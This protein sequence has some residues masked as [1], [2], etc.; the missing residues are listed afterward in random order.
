[1]HA[2]VFTWGFTGILGKLIT[3]DYYQIVF[4]RVMIAGFSLLV[5][6]LATKKTFRIKN[7][8]DVWKT[9][10]IGVLVMLHW[11]TF[12]K[13]IQ[14]STTSVA[15]LCLSTTTLHVSW[16][17]PI[18]MKRKFI[19]MEFIL[20]LGV[21]GGISFVAG[22]IGA[23]QYEG[24]FWGLIS[25]LMAAF[26]SVFNLRLNMDGIKS[27]SLT[28]YEMFVAAACLGIVLLSS[29]KMNAAFFQVEE[30][31]WIWLFLLGIVCTTAPFMLMIDVAKKLGAFT[32]SLTINLEPVYS[33][34]LAIIILHENEILG[35][36]FYWGALLI[37]MI[38]F[39]NPILKHYMN[40]RKKSIA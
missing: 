38:V 21:I 37:I 32:S 5:F 8:K 20:G 35:S 14:V 9:I 29:G 34:V 33:I 19:P 15:V 36:S 4:F 17:E 26:F 40:K 11:L 12:F 31:N 18:V 7:R 22:N 13:S 27:S 25:A 6:L 24:I 30:M 1:M 2:I 10:G 23:D 3:L 16:I 28:L 39:L